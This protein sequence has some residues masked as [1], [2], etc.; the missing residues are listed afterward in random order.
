MRPGS[1]DVANDMKNKQ[2]QFYVHVQKYTFYALSKK[3][4]EIKQYKN[5]QT[6]TN[7]HTHTHT[8]HLTPTNLNFVN[9]LNRILP[10]ATELGKPLLRGPQNRRLV[11]APV[12]RVAMGDLGLRDQLGVALEQRNDSGVAFG[13]D[14]WGGVVENISKKYHHIDYTHTHT[15]THT[16]TNTYTHTHTHT[17]THTQNK[18]AHACYNW[19]Q[20][21]RKLDFLSTTT[22]VKSNI[23]IISFLKTHIFAHK[24]WGCVAVITPKLVDQIILDGNVIFDADIIIVEAVC[25]CRVD[26]PRA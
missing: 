13:E 25:R 17:H 20:S 18:Q 8:Q 26:Q 2:M 4:Y 22:H 6:Q 12:V 11:R 9:S 16:H 14:L 19:L 5:K 15:H 23:N 21:A 10:D 7:T 3:Q 24:L 1:S